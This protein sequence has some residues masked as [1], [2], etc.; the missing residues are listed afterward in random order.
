MNFCEHDSLYHTFIQVIRLHYHRTHML[1]EKIGIYPGQPP[2]LMALYHN[3]GQSQREL[4][5][6]LKIKPSTITVMLRRME[7]AELVG[8]RLD[9]EDQRVSR[10]YLTQQGKEICEKVKEIIK[11]IDSECFNGFTIEEKVL[12]RRLFIQMKDNLSKEEENKLDG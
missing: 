10:V 5:D 6:K 3:D 1:L 2:M 12:L 7:K 4:A 8:R 11:I 9:T